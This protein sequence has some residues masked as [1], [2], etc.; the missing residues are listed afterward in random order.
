MPSW[1]TGKANPQ[2]DSE[3]L[4]A[5]DLNALEL[6]SYTEKG[7]PDKEGGHDH[8]NDNEDPAAESNLCTLGAG[9][10]VNQALLNCEDQADLR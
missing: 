9:P 10:Y 1:R 5:N 3:R 7:D 2:A 4:Q 8:M 6:Q